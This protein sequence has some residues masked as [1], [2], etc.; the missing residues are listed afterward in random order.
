MTM[1]LKKNQVVEITFTGTGSQGEAVGHWNGQAVFV[2]FGAPGDKALVKIVKNAKTHAFGRLEKVLEPAPCRVEPDCPSFS[3][4]G[5]CTSRHISYQAELEWKTQ[6][7]RD[8]LQRIGGFSDLPVLPIVPGESRCGYRNKAL[9]PLGTNGQGQ[10]VM[11]FFARNSHR[12]VDCR[13]CRLHP[14]EFHLA[15][16]AFRRWAEQYGDPV[17]SEITHT[18]RMR[19]LYLRKAEAT[20]QIMVCVVVNG[21]G[22]HHEKEL[23]EIMA[24]S[25]PGL[26]SLVI[27]SNRERTNVALGKRCRAI[28][29]KGF[30]MDQLCGL[31]FAIS[32]L[33]FY[34]VNHS[35]TQRLYAL[36]ADYA[37]ISKDG[38]L[39][40]LYC[41]AGA[42]GLSMAGRAGRLIGVEVIPQAVEDARENA[43]RNG[44]ENC[45]FLCADAAQAAKEL[46]RRGERPQVVV[47]DPP[48]KGCGK[49]LTQIVAGM[50]PQRVVYISCDPATLAR[51][52]RYF[53]E[54]GYCPQKA[55]PVDMFGGTAHVETVVL[56][57]KA[58]N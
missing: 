51:D 41:G 19:W 53:A 54:L 49:E 33:S 23:A 8:A 20:G 55:Q 24:G 43:R 39:L 56:L 44:I 6:R 1:P 58:Q 4:C 29:G 14:P 31:D 2:P 34:Q 27:N 3:R 5:G 26:A 12:I 7:V 45:E 42:I 47:L 15:A 9:L 10:L 40:D 36:A 35:Q 13:E 25:V 11:G 32:P 16:E 57:S 22:L 18:G 38:L 30:L 50:A 52:L 21:N 37:N 46:A 17:Y 28:W 48:R